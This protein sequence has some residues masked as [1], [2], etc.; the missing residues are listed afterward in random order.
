MSGLSFQAGHPK[1]G[2][3]ILGPSLSSFHIEDIR[4]TGPTGGRAN[5]FIDRK[6][7]GIVQP[8]MEVRKE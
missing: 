1:M 2:R 7:D 4:L 8:V 6:E 3:A 5:I